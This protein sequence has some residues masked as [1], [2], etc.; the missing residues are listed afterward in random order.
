MADIVS[1]LIITADDI[2]IPIFGIC[3]LGEKIFD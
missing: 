3:K 2:A 1:Y